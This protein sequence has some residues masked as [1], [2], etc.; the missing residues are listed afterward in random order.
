[1][2]ELGLEETTRTPRGSEEEED[3]QKKRDMPESEPINH[4]PIKN[5]QR[6]EIPERWRKSQP[7]TPISSGLVSDISLSPSERSEISVAQTIEVPISTATSAVNTPEEDQD[8]TMAAKKEK[9]H[10]RQE[11]KGKN[12]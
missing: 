1:M 9:D 12:E 3:H 7:N 11:R 6:L 2:G 10:R 8:E 5:L 4:E